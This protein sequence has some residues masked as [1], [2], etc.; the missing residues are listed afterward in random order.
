[1]TPNPDAPVFSSVL[2]LA[3]TYGIVSFAML[4]MTVWR[5]HARATPPAP[6]GLSV[7]VFITCFD[8]PLPLVRRTAVGARAIR[9]PH[10][11]YILDDGRRDEV[12]AVAR[13]LGI[14]YIRR[15]TNEHAKAGNLNNALA[16]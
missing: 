2:A 7:D 5:L 3:E 11:T 10:R 6:P 13:E 14:G 8:E 12:S 16:R 15:S 9:Y 1:S 4:I